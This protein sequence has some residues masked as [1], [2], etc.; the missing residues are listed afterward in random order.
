MEVAWVLPF[1]VF[2]GFWRGFE[3]W[4]MFG[5]HLWVDFLCGVLLVVCSLCLRFDFMVVA[6]LCIFIFG[7]ECV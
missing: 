1:W 2:C 5:C 4:V 6:F 3:F 7:F